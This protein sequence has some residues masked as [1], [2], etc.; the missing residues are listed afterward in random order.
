MVENLSGNGTMAPGQSVSFGFQGK[1]GDA[2]AGL[3]GW[4]F[5][6]VPLPSSPAATSLSAMA[7]FTVTS[8]SRSGFVATVR[9]TNMGTVPIGGWALQFAF[10]PR[11]TSTTS[12]VIVR[13]IGQLHVIRDDGYNGV[14][15]PGGSVS[16]Q[17]RGSDCKL[18]SGPVDY[19]LDGLPIS[20]NTIL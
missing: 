2:K 15:A 14:V 18:Q 10:S 5:N 6:G 13:H 1:P 17:I 3:T 4:V 11:I 20:G 12:A 8:Q 7:T 19:V 16:F 9:I